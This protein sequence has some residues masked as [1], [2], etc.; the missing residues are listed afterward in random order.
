MDLNRSG[1]HLAWFEDL[2]KER[3][4]TETV[5]NTLYDDGSIIWDMLRT[6]LI[7]PICSGNKFFKLK[8]YLLDA[9]QKKHTNI[10]T[11]GGAWSN[12]IVATALAARACGLGSV[13]YIRGER[14]ATPSETLREAGSLG[15]EFRFVNRADYSKIPPVL[16]GE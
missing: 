12:H 1:H 14:S 10:V 4:I 5:E 6:D 2:A 11:S 16:P 15:M 13:G 7:H 8:Y 3:I 9:I